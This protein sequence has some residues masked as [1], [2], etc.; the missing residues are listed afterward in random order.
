MPPS[1]IQRGCPGCSKFLVFFCFLE[2][3]AQSYRTGNVI[4]IESSPTPSEIIGPT[5]C[6]PN[7]LRPEKGS[8]CSLILC[9]IT[10]CPFFG[11]LGLSST[12]FEASGQN[13][14]YPFL[15]TSVLTRIDEWKEGKEEGK[16]K[17]RKERRKGGRKERRKVGKKDACMNG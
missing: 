5:P 2:N 16:E 17:R 3:K 4:V 7:Q 14:W 9:G 11:G 6:S 1:L 8:D 13:A 12:A 15:S 10:F